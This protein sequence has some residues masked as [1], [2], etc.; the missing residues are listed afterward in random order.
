M[1]HRKKHV[2]KLTTDL[3]TDTSQSL[4]ANGPPAVVYGRASP[5][6]IFDGE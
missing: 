6:Y 4:A 2:E 3:S 1:N 5:S